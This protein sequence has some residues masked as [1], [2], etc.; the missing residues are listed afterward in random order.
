MKNTTLIAIDLAKDTFQIRAE[1][2][3]G[4]NLGEHKVSRNRLMETIERYPKGTKIVMEACSG[5][6]Y[7]GHRLEERG[8]KALLIAPHHVSPFVK[9][10]KNDRKDAQGIADAA[11][12]ET[13]RFI[14]L[15]S[16]VQ[17]DLQALHRVRDR[18]QQQRTA[19]MNE[20]RGLVAEYGVTFPKGRA[21]LARVR[22]LLLES[23][24]KT[25]TIVGLVD[26]LYQEVV[27]LE[28]KVAKVTQ[29]L[30]EFTKQSEPCKRLMTVPGISY[31]TATAFYAGL[32]HYNFKNGREVGAFLGLVPRQNS[33]G[34]KEKLG[35]ITKTGDK[36][37]RKLLVHG[38]RAVLRCAHRHNNPYNS[39]AL[40]LRTQKGYNKA[41]VAL[42]NKNARIA[43]RLLSGDTSFIASHKPSLYAA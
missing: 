9:T 13:T 39:W 18:Y 14:P 34:G 17:Q 10:Q 21:A 19:V 31:I 41:A 40:R 26:E 29:Q 32:A 43:W 6:H 28:E 3:A 7:W 4:R 42:A 30:R 22:D 33:S 12:R 24:H 11:S 20:I 37:L 8:Y 36:Y 15:K 2:H 35:S 27:A 25:E 23:P 16:V 38:A 1:N 5:A